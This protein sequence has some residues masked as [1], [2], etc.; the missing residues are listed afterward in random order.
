MQYPAKMGHPETSYINRTRITDSEDEDFNPV[1]SLIA[2]LSRGLA[3]E[4][5][6]L[7]QLAEYYQATS[8]EGGGGG[9]MRHWPSSI[10]SKSIRSR[11][12]SGA[13]SNEKWDKWSLHFL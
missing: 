5:P 7:R 9:V 3:W 8:L 6:S 13:L 4:S 1:G 10:F 11:V 2:Y 12:E